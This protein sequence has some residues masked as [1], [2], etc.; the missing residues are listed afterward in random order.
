MGSLWFEDVTRPQGA[1]LEHDVTVDVAVLGAGIVGLTTAL[2]LE[3]EGATRGGAGGRRVAAGASGYNTAK[4]SSLHGLTYR[5]LARS[6]G[7]E[8]ARAY[9][10]ANEAGIARVFELAGELGIDCD[11]RRK[12]NYTYTEYAVGSRPGARGGGGGGRARASGLVRRGRRSSVRGRRARCASR[13]RP[14]STR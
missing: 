5:K 7:A 13:S 8:A 3:R 6:L 9:G 11:L 2:L 1:A 10:E 14:S 12:P 4:L